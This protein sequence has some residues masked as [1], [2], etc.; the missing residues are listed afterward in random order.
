MANDASVPPLSKDNRDEFDSFKHPDDASFDK[1]IG[2]LDRAYH[3][4]FLMMWRSF[5][6][7]MAAALGATVGAALVFVILFY[8][9]RTLNFAPFAKQLQELVIPASILK[10]LDPSASPS[11]TLTASPKL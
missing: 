10:Q 6:H 8:V 2:A 4:P 7:G 1:F 9:L 3:R 11:P 5:L